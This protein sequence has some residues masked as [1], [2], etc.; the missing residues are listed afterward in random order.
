[1]AY[2]HDY[3]KA[4]TRLVSILTKLYNGEQLS[5]KDLADEFNVSTR[6]IQRDFNERLISFPIYQDNRLWKMQDGFKLEKSTS[7]E[8]QVV[9][10]IMEKLVDSVGNQFSS[11]ARNLLSKIKN[12]DYNPIYAKLNME[13][14]E[15]VEDVNG[16]DMK[17]DDNLES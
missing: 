17:G 12:H 13:D 7:I 2:K 15:D 4:L 16:E 14:I 9:L 1:M 10:D 5:V 3:D 11:K 6:T 8:E